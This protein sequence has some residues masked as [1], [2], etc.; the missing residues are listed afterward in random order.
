VRKPPATRRAGVGGAAEAV[1]EDERA[2]VDVGRGAALREDG[3]SGSDEG[4]GERGRK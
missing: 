1:G 2:G 3:R 4:G